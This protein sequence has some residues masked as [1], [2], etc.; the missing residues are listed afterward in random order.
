MGTILLIGAMTIGQT[1]LPAQ[2]PDPNNSAQPLPSAPKF[3][4]PTLSLQLPGLDLPEHQSDS[5]VALNLLQLGE[6]T[7]AKEKLDS[8]SADPRASAFPEGSASPDAVNGVPP[9]QNPGPAD[10]APILL[11]SPWAQIEPSL[12]FQSEL[13]PSLTDQSESIRAGICFDAPLFTGTRAVPTSFVPAAAARF[14]GANQTDL[15]FGMSFNLGLS[16][17]TEGWGVFALDYRF[18][19]GSKSL[20]YVT[21]NG[22]QDPLVA[23]Q[24][25]PQNNSYDYDP[26]SDSYVNSG[27]PQTV[28]VPDS[29]GS[30]QV[31][32]R[33]TINQLDLTYQTPAW[34]WTHELGIFGLAGLRGATFLL[35]DDTASSTIG[36]QAKDSFYGGG[37]FAGFGY[38]CDFSPIVLFLR[39][40]CGGM[41]GT[42]YQLDQELVVSNSASRIQAVALQ[43]FQNVWTLRIE[44][45][46]VW[47]TGWNGEACVKYRFDR[48]W[49]LDSLAG[50]T[51]GWTDNSVNLEFCWRF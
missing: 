16:Y 51:L 17:S 34:H 41:P 49:G 11:P 27:T 37:P 25:N 20:D 40:D 5:C 38:S 26:A 35:E 1:L 47:R 9:M 39:F 4:V 12:R 45:G 44:S 42:S 48:W 21:A 29:V 6:P 14:P 22:P 32:T 46:V 3:S 28:L 7:D 33:Y 15:T 2:M 43:G 18:S 31:S 24:I 30:A 8:D 50:S 19:S 23:N 10:S 36:Q 13:G